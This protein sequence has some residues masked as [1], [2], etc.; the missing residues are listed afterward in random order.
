MLFSYNST[1]KEIEMKLATLILAIALAA[2]LGTTAY[3]ER[4]G[5]QADPLGAPGAVTCGVDGGA[6]LVDVIWNAV[7]GAAKYSVDFECEDPTGTVEIGVEYE[8]EERL[9]DT[10]AS[11]P[12]DTFPLEI[13]LE[14]EG[15]WACV[16]KVKGLNP[17]GRK[18]SHP[19]GVALCE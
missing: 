1:T 11:V 13:I 15:A 19:Q 2:T 10:F 9:T 16:A 5:K 4:G 12:F 18:Q 17:P 3:A 8:P 7:P 14:G 6:L